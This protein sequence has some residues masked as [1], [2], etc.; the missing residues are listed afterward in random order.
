MCHAAKRL[1]M[2]RLQFKIGSPVKT[3]QF[4]PKILL[5]LHIFLLLQS[6][7]TVLLSVISLLNEPNTYSPANVDASV[8]YRR[9]RE[10]KGKDKEYENIIRLVL[11][12]FHFQNLFNF[13][14]QKKFFW[15]TFCMFLVFFSFI[16]FSFFEEDWIDFFFLIQCGERKKMNFFSVRKKKYK[17][18]SYKNLIRNEWIY[19][20]SLP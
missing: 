12:V 18:K 20:M 4:H 6:V 15:K 11:G 19:F 8:M 13:L 17:R 3:F 14:D 10:S 2:A 7:R 16:S 9:F 1:F 5:C